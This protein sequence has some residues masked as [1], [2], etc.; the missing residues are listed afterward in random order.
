MVEDVT[1]FRSDGEKMTEDEWNAGWIRAL[2]LRLSGEVLDDVNG[3]GEPIKDDTFLILINS[4]HEDLAFHLPRVS[5]R[6]IEWELC[7]DTRD[8][9]T[10]EPIRRDP[11]FDFDLKARSVAVWRQVLRPDA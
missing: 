8:S 1:W 9:A 4:H 5:H 10:P 7:F 11:G 3:V 6:E 2:G